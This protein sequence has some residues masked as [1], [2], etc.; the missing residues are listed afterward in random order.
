MKLSDGEK[1][2]L[3]MLSKMSEKHNPDAD[4]DLKFIEEAIISNNTWGIPWKYSGIPFEDNKTPE[5]VK[6]VVNILEMWH[7]IEASYAA[8]SDD[9]KSRLEKEAEPFG[10]NPKFRGFDGNNE[11]Q[12]GIAQFLIEQLDRFGSFKDRDLNS[13]MPSIDTYRRMYSAFKPMR[14]ELAG[15][16]LT[17]NQLI[18][19]LKAMTHPDHQ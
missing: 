6:E 1:L 17:A 9:D 3:M 4:T 14:Q 2:I 8:L 16:L 18:E 11:P 13:H 10:K 7:F 12:I 19:I 5:D 15:E